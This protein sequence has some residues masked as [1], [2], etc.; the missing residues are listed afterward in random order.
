MEQLKYIRLEG[1]ETRKHFLKHP[2]VIKEL[3]EQRKNKKIDEDDFML[4]AITH[5]FEDT[6]LPIELDYIF[7]DK[8]VSNSEQLKI[9]IR[10]CF[11]YGTKFHTKLWRGYNHLAILELENPNSSIVK[12]LKPYS[13]KKRWDINL[14]LCK[15]KESEPCKEL[16]KHVIEKSEK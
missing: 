13:D 11:N 8:N 16:I 12:S 2:L 3:N 10:G 9:V 7:E 14:I 6:D 5:L 15:S 4:V 1:I